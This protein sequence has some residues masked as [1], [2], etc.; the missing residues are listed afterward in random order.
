MEVSQSALAY[1]LLWAFLGGLALGCVYDILR[2]LRLTDTTE[3]PRV[4]LIC[5]K[6]ALPQ[7]LRPHIYVKIKQPSVRIK[8]LARGIRLFFEDVLFCVLFAVTAI[9]LLYYTN[10]G[11]LRLSAIACMLIGLGV[12]FA[13]LGRITKPLFMLLFVLL[14]A[15]LC[16]TT[17]LLIYPL[18]VLWRGLERPRRWLIH[19]YCGMISRI[20]SRIEQRRVIKAQR[21]NN[22]A[23][24]TS[25]KQ[26][27]RLW[28]QQP[29]GKRVFVAGGKRHISE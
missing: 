22:V 4:A 13:T 3:S 14:C 12:Y 6:L 21:K 23:D 28:A 20:R 27:R 18:R 24:S 10:D 9:L 7:V 25:L 17:A 11:Q 2:V 5:G 29:D 15:V 19:R 8:R 1:M 26:T 16:W